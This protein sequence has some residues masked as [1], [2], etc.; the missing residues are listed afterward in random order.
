MRF[1]III[2]IM[3]IIN[4]FA[5]V[6]HNIILERGPFM[7][8]PSME[9]HRKSELFN[10]YFDQNTTLGLAFS[11]SGQECCYITHFHKYVIIYRFRKFWIEFIYKILTLLSLLFFVGLLYTYNKKTKVIGIFPDGFQFL[12]HWIWACLWSSFQGH[13]L[14][15]YV[16]FYHSFRC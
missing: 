12:W 13:F 15:H 14:R 7:I 10:L 3:I 5:F 6:V 11:K 16:I 4:L 8:L 9:G 2:L 1:I